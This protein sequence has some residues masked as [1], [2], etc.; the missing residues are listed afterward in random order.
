MELE[1]LFSNI[2]L[3]YNYNGNENLQ[4]VEEILSTGN[5]N[6][7]YKMCSYIKKNFT[8]DENHLIYND[9]PVQQKQK[10]KRIRELIETILEIYPHHPDLMTKHF[11]EFYMIMKDLCCT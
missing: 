3:D 1:N 5:I 11:Y 9:L 2:N 7:I 8:I 10:I 4:I 6:E